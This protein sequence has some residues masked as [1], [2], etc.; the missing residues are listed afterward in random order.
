MRQGGAPPTGKWIGNPLGG[1]KAPEALI[2]PDPETR[3]SA[4]AARLSK[5]A[6]GHPMA[7]WLGFMAG[8]SEAQH[9]AATSLAPL[10]GVDALLI[11]QSVAA[12]MPPLPADGHQRN[13][14]WREGLTILLDGI[15]DKG[16]P[17]PARAAVTTLRKRSA[18]EIENMASHF[19]AGTP[20]SDDIGATLYVAAALQVY[21]T[22]MAGRFDAAEL[23]LL[24]Q[25]G[26]CPCCGSTAVSGLITAS[27]PTPGTRYLYCSMCS[28]A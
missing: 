22:A 3:F 2:L 25:R 23:R 15:D 4:T 7:E 6:K 19:L 8:L 20:R 27:G 28:T 11:A 24:P 18:D 14:L 13:P 16:L 26:L 5:L 21:F 9:R 10:H 17:A 1:V 12:R